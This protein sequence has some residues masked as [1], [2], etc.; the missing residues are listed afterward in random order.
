MENQE[1]TLLERASK[2]LETLLELKR[3][4]KKIGN[5]DLAQKCEEIELE[6]FPLSQEEIDADEEAEKLN[7]A[8]R[9]VELGI[10]KQTCYRIARTLEQL[11]KKKGKFSIADSA[12]IVVDSKR[13]FLRSEHNKK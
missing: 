4:A 9:M 2:K 3:F 12:K 11:K 1:K 5:Y 13:V 7:L 8:F 10:D 6:K